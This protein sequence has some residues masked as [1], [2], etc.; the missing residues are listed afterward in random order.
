MLPVA[1]LDIVVEPRPSGA[2]KCVSATI[3]LTNVE[4]SAVVVRIAIISRKL[5]V[6]NEAVILC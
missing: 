3:G 4:Y 6:T 5:V 2:E 1:N